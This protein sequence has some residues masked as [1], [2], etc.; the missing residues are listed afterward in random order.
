MSILSEVEARSRSSRTVCGPEI[1]D[2]LFVVGNANRI[3]KSFFFQD[4]LRLASN[5]DIRE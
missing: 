2:L 5:Q 1:E 4:D 3:I